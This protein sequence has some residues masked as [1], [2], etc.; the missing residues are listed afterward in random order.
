[1]NSSTGGGSG[2]GW[3]STL[4]GGAASLFG[5]FSNSIAAPLANALPGDSLDNLLRLTNN[6]GG[7]RAAGGPVA[8]N[9]LYRV[10]EKGPEMFAAANGDQFLLTAGHGGRVV[11]NG[12]FGNGFAQTNN[13]T[14]Q[15]SVDRRT[16]E[17]IAAELGRRTRTAMYRMG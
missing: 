16:A 15:G 14:V 8:P 3:L 5:G 6:F 9:T 10:N 7:F 17:Q 2:G 11:P 1:M 13:I 4:I 12:A